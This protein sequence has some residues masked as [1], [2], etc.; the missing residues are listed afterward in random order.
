MSFRKCASVLATTIS[1][2]FALNVLPMFSASQ[3][4]EKID[5]TIL[6]FTNTSQTH[7]EAS[8]VCDVLTL[9]L[10]DGKTQRMSM[11]EMNRKGPNDVTAMW[12]L[13]CFYIVK[14]IWRGLIHTDKVMGQA[15]ISLEITSDGKHKVTRKAVYVPG[16]M[17]CL[18]NG[19]LP[20]KAKEFWKGVSSAV[21]YIEF[22]E[23]KIPDFK[24]AS[25]TIDV[26]CGRDQ[27]V[28]PRY[29]FCDYQG[30]LK[31]D[32]EGLIHRAKTLNTR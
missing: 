6:A 7:I 28:F 9:R 29:P 10:K 25:A 23:M 27:E 18:G 19:P 26:V 3:D 21:E 12:N 32:K 14:D 2:I 15:N 11:R 20:A 8:I 30:I 5:G 13:F 17:P 22:K 1:C 16:C 4:A 24:V 31:R